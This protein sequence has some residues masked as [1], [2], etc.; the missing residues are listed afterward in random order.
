MEPSSYSQCFLF[1][2]WCPVIPRKNCPGAPHNDFS[3]DLP[4]SWNPNV[5]EPSIFFLLPVKNLTS[6]PHGFSK[7]SPFPLLIQITYLMPNLYDLI[8][9]GGNLPS[10]LTELPYIHAHK[11]EIDFQH[12]L[13]TLLHFSGKL[14]FLL[15]KVTL[16]NLLLC[17]N[18][19]LSLISLLI[20][21]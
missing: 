21:N 13:A 7:Y 20:L 9:A 18:H 15:F 4:F 11:L 19:L 14:A 17:S 16:S 5:S 6:F 3:E 2:C 10:S 1:P 12:S 8:L